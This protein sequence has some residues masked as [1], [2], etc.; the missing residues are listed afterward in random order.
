MHHVEIKYNNNKKKS[1]SL[2]ITIASEIGSCYLQYVLDNP[3]SIKFVFLIFQ[4][5]ILSLIIPDGLYTSCM[6]HP[7]S[8]EPHKKNNLVHMV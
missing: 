1:N 4:E 2:N 3:Y 7:R 8:S 5:S 6:K